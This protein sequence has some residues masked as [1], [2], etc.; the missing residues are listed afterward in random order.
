M[1]ALDAAIPPN[2]AAHRRDT[3]SAEVAKTNVRGSDPPTLSG[4]D[5]LPQQALY[6]EN[7]RLD[8]LPYIPTD[9]RSALDVGCARGGFGVTLRRVLG[10][11]ARI[12]G[13][14][15]VPVQAAIA[16]QGHGYDEVVD[17]YFPD[18]LAH[19]GVEPFDLI[20]FNDVLEHILEP[21]DVLVQARDHL[22]QDGRVVAAIPS[23]QYAPVVMGLLRG[24]WDY[25]DAGTLDRT[26][27]RFFTRA[28]MVEMFDRAGYTVELCEGINSVRRE[29]KQDPSGPRRLAK[30]LLERA[31]GNARFLHF[32][33]V[34][35]RD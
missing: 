30:L 11:D 29:W 20:A 33:V 6:G 27:V 13:V 16:R 26:H 28:T 10:P 5:R 14:E 2:G 9:A 21:E 17:G 35:N 22:A 8:V 23:I 31:L 34:A 15:A 1:S 25:T 4:M 19:E 24:R 7:E 32:V 3:Q 12:V 18:A